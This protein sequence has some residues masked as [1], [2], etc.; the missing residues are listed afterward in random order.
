MSALYGII[1]AVS[2][3][4]ILAYYFV[5]RKRDIWLL[6]LFVC[7]AVCDLGYFLLSAAKNLEF[8][9]WANRIAYLGSVFLPFSILMMIMNLSRFKYPK[10]FPQILIGINAVMFFIV[11]SGG[12][13]PIYYKDVSFEIINGVGTLIKAYGPL[14]NLYKVF[15]FVYF[16]AMIAIIIYTAKKKTVISVKHSIFLA[17]VVIGNIVI[18]LIENSIKAG[19]E[20]MSVS[21]IITEGLILFLYGVL[22]DYGL[23]DTERILSASVTVQSETE[24]NASDEQ[25]ISISYFEQEQIDIIFENWQN[26]RLLSQ[27]EKEVLALIMQNKKRKDIAD[28]LFVTESTIKKHTSSIFKKLNIN[29]RSELFENAKNYLNNKKMQ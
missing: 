14:H 20:F 4:M 29:N 24:K 9:L 1:F 22:Q 3:L 18:W 8:A 19:F 7:V 21:Y 23:T 16:S 26:L 25:I 2:L 6:L 10:W 13:L 11:S 5:D 27:R 15:L 28:E 17:F 12:W